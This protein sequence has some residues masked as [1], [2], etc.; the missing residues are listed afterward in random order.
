MTRE[1]IRTET[2]PAPSGGYSQAVR[3]GAFI[4]VA[5]QGSLDRRTGEVKGESIEEQT[6]LTL[7]NIEAIL[8]AAGASLRDVVKATVHLR[9]IAE[10][11][12][13]DAAYSARMPDPKPVRTTV[14]SGLGAGLKVEI[15]VVA[16]R[17]PGQ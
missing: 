5:G 10:F 4:Y 13:F 17:E 14:A 3:A 7:D 1:I 9:D 12:R 8:E 11:E 16:Y 6:T 2:A 15:D